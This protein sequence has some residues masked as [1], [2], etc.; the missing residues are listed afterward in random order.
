MVAFD[1]KTL[2]QCLDIR[3]R[4]GVGELLDVKAELLHVFGAEGCRRTF[5]AVRGLRYQV[6]IPTTARLSHRI[7]L[8]RCFDK[9]LVSKLAQ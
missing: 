8:A 2:H 1:L 5:K 3:E 9:K 7:K 6:G 4:T